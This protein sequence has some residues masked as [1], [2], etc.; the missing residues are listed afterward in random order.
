MAHPSP[1]AAGSAHATPHPGGSAARLILNWVVL[2]V[3]TFTTFGVSKLPIGDYHLAAAIAIACIKVTLVVLFFMHLW[4]AEGTD[5]IIF[6]VS[7]FFLL[8]LLF[9]VLADI[10]TRFSLSNS[11]IP[12]MPRVDQ[13]MLPS[14]MP[15]GVGN[16]AEGAPG[17]SP[18]E[19]GR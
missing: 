12:A 9:F 19:P 2:C 8:V 6:V 15:P 13:K 17:G 1:P 7:F 18:G 10:G 3:L 16:G 5:R 4:H 14:A 11:R